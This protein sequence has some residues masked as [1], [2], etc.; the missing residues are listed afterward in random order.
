M[1]AVAF[2]PDFLLAFF[3]ERVFSTYIVLF[4][5]RSERRLFRDDTTKN[6]FL[7]EDFLKEIALIDVSQTGV[8]AIIGVALTQSKHAMCPFEKP[9]SN[10]F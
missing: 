8:A 7:F 6:S 9:T 3:E 2:R 5:I 4:S 1:S 10:E